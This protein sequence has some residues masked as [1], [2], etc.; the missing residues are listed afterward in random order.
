MF[1]YAR[2]TKIVNN[3]QDKVGWQSQDNAS[4]NHF[5]SF[6]SQ[7]PVGILRRTGKKIF[8][9]FDHWEQLAAA[10]NSFLD[11]S[12][13]AAYGGRQV[14]VP[15]V[16]DSR[17]HGSPTKKRFETLA[18]YYNVTALNHTLRSR[19]HGTLISWKEF[20]YVCQDKL[21]V[22]VHFDYTNLKKL[23]NIAELHGHFFF[24]TLA[25]VTNP[26]ISRLKEQFV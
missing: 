11:L 10:T 26:Q 18:L 17:L 3:S 14:V 21:D 2:N 1:F 5:R 20:Q 19:G 7:G 4:A 9:T 8:I 23:Q 25:N 6:P 22:L 12:A 16:K 24:A 15:F 13:L